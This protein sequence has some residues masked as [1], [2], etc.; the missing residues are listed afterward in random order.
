[1]TENPDNPQTPQE[2]EA[3]A[4]VRQDA[5][6]AGVRAM[7]DLVD[8]VKSGMLESQREQGEREMQIARLRVDFAK[9]FVNK[10]FWFLMTIIAIAASAVFTDRADLGAQIIFAVL[11][12]VAGTGF[13]LSMRK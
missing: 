7:N 1:M 4:L 13:G 10:F 5:E 11:G 9:E 3:G 12:F 6:T 2:K 8:A